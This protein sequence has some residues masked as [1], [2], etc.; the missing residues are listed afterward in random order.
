M[1]KISDLRLGERPVEGAKQQPYCVVNCN[2]QP[3]ACSLFIA[4]NS[5][6]HTQVQ[7]LFAQ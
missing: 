1:S 6:T 3:V 4:E 7:L 5:D 2:V